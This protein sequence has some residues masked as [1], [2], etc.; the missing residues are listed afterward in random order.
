MNAIA[1][2]AGS[3]SASIFNGS[4]SPGFVFAAKG[5]L[6][7]GQD[8][9]PVF[10]AAPDGLEVA[11]T[12]L[13]KF[14]YDLPDPLCTEDRALAFLSTID[15]PKP[16]DGLKEIVSDLP[17]ANSTLLQYL[18]SFLK[19]LA[20]HLWDKHELIVVHPDSVTW[21]P[22]LEHCVGKHLVCR[23]V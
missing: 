8:P 19:L 23:H 11:G 15:T 21:L 2:S 17:E 3:C 16:V 4:G 22:R 9:T 12:L 18:I 13:L 7:A 14:L 10:D 6:E 1:S 5:T 20:Q